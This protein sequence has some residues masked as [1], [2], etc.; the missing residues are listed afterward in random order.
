MPTNDDDDD[1]DD[2]E[3]LSNENWALSRMMMLAVL[4]HQVMMIEEMMD[5][6]SMNSNEVHSCHSNIVMVELVNEVAS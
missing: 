4:Y 2:D 1:E 3:D 5:H 6:L